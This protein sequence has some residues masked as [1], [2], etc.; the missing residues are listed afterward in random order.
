MD[1]VPNQW[2]EIS[3]DCLPL[4]S[5]GR[6]DVPMDASP[7]YRARCERILGAIES[8]GT[9]N[10]YF[11]YNAECKFHLSNDPTIGTVTF[12]FE[13]TL[14]TDET[15]THSSRCDLSTELAWE[16]CDWITE[17]IVEWLSLSVSRAVLVE[18]DR[19]IEVGDLGR[20]KSRIEELQKQQEDSGGFLGMYL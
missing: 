7:V 9:H 14:L 2:V 16:T 6:L 1:N 4:R 8:H 10:S 19:Y 5:V 13:G 15:D 18:F 17:P 11:L 20:T 3:F 12:R